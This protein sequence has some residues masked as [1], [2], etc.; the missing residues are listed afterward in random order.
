M[1]HAE[2]GLQELYGVICWNARWDGNLNL[3]IEF[4]QPSLSVLE[5]RTTGAGNKE[6]AEFRR[7][8]H[9]HLNGEWELWILSGYWKLS[10]QDFGD[11]TIASSYKRKKIALAGLS[12]QKLT[13]ATVNPMTS[14]TQLDFD[15]GARLLIRRISRDADG[16]IW[17]LYKPTGFC[18][19][20]RADGRYK[21][22][23]G[24]TP[25]QEIVWKSLAAT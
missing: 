11:V 18:L 14:A 3:R 21:D 23:P 7:L 5:P 9:V 22:F 8:R 2:L 4:G 20:V 1:N 10:M 15:L 6:Q 17:S 19:S 16:D 12:G 13:G 24:D 25:P